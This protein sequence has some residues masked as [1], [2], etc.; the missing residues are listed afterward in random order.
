MVPVGGALVVFQYTTGESSGV[1]AASL[2]VNPV[3]WL[4]APTT[5]GR[6]STKGMF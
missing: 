3:V 6:R 5:V 1:G 2:V 4:T